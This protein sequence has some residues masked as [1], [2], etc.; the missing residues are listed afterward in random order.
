MLLL[1]LTVQLSLCNYKSST[2]LKSRNC[3]TT[4]KSRNCLAPV[5]S[6]NLLPPLLCSPALLFTLM[7]EFLISW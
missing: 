4:L 2:E 3:N 6:V 5:L 1:A 7:R